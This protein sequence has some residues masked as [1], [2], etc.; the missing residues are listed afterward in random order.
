M[1]TIADRHGGRQP[2]TADDLAVDLPDCHFDL[3]VVDRQVA[4]SG[5][6]TAVDASPPKSLPQFLQTNQVK[7]YGPF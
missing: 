4:I 3:T 7:I 2:I 5:E 1:L 6:S